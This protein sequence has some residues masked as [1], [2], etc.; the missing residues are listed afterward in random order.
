VDVSGISCAARGG[1]VRPGSPGA[2]RRPWVD[3]LYIVRGDIAV[4]GWLEI[5][6]EEMTY[7]WLV[8]LLDLLEESTGITESPWIEVK[9]RRNGLNVAEAV[10]ALANADGGLVLVGILDD[11]EAAETRGAERIVGVPEK[12]YE[13]LTMSL[14]SS[15]QDELPEIQP[16]AIPNKPG[17]IAMI[18]RVDADAFAHPVVVSGKV[19]VRVGSSSI[20]ADR[21]TVE[22]LVDRDRNSTPGGMTGYPIPVN[23]ES[24]PFWESAYVPQSVFRV[25]SSIRLPY[26]VLEQPLLSSLDVK[27]ALESVEASVLPDAQ[28]LVGDLAKRQMQSSRPWRLDYRRSRDFRVSILPQDSTTWPDDAVG[29]GAYVALNGQTLN[30]VMV[31]WLDPSEDA[32]PIPMADAYLLLLG[33]L[34]STREL[35]ETMA[36]R[37]APSPVRR[38][39]GW[40]GWMQPANYEGAFDDV[41]DLGRWSRASVSAG[42][43]QLLPEVVLRDVDGPSFDWLVREWLLLVLADNGILDHEID[44]ERLVAPDWLA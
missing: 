5:P 29:A 15:L 35:L 32:R 13:S 7:A 41:I 2:W 9:S 21:A 23:A 25:R 42:G 11:H 43:G 18:L 33:L 31:A 14:M 26:K 39:G 38:W 10:G 40:T 34:T 3:F 8:E 36:E 24:M 6:L 37:L 17:Q 12:E 1:S 22:R 30:A 4:N 20:N 19:K 16:I 44:V 28:W 27:A